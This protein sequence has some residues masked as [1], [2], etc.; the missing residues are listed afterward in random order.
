MSTTGNSNNLCGE[1][2]KQK[3]QKIPPYLTSAYVCDE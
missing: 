3:L 1:E 2:L